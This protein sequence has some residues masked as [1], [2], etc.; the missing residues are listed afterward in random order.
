MVFD[1]RKG[2]RLDI[3]CQRLM[4]KSLQIKRKKGGISRKMPTFAAK[5]AV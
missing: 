2:M 4:L 1:W 3:D 5:K